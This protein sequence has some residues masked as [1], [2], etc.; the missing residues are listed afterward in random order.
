MDCREIVT[1]FGKKCIELESLTIPL[2][3]K[4]KNCTLSTVKCVHE[5]YQCYELSYPP[6]TVNN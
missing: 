3:N 4:E 6:D 5:K 2:S 1:E